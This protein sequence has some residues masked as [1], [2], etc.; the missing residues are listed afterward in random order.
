MGNEVSFHGTCA[1]INRIFYALP[2]Q[3]TTHNI[4]HPPSTTHPPTC[5][6]NQLFFISPS[7]EVQYNTFLNNNHNVSM[8]KDSRLVT[9]NGL[10]KHLLKCTSCCIGCTC[11]FSANKFALSALHSW[12]KHKVNCHGRIT[13]ACIAK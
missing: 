6:I 9:Q 8:L 1:N 11:I 7:V 13:R 3:A 4:L 12:H 2:W 5:P 10:V